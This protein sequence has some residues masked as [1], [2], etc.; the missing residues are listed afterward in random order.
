MA[1]SD[2]WYLV[3]NSVVKIVNVYS[4]LPLY[5]LSRNILYPGAVFFDKEPDK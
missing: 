4:M 1:T 5:V 2:Y 3:L